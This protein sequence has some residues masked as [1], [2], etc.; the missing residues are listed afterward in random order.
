MHAYNATQS[1]LMGYS[2]HYLMFGHRPRLPV[3]FYFPTLRSA[4]VPKC[5]A[6][7]KCVDKYVATV[8]DRLRAAL[9]EAQAQ[10]MAEAQRQ[11]WYYNQKIGTIGF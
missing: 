1:V 11:K 8:Q 10:S 9:Q 3:D 6:S 2:P 7:A 5:G 4:E